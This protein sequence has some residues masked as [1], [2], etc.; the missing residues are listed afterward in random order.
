MKVPKNIA[1]KFL[2]QENI[3]HVGIQGLPVSAHLFSSNIRKSQSLECNFS[4]GKNKE[5][6]TY[7]NHKNKIK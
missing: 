7:I 3:V 1:K 5:T 4:V 2:P 6:N